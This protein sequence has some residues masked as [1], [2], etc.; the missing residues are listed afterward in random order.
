M[1]YPIGTRIR[2]RIVGKVSSGPL[3]IGK[4]AWTRVNSEGY[5]H[6]LFLLADSVVQTGDQVTAEF[7]AT[8]TGEQ[9]DSTATTMVTEEGSGANHFLYLNSPSVTVVEPEPERTY[10]EKLAARIDGPPTTEGTTAVT[11]EIGDRVRVRINA[12]AGAKTEPSLGLRA[13]TTVTENAGYSYTHFLYLNSNRVV[14]GS[15]SQVTAEFDA[16][17]TG[18]F[19]N[20][21]ARTTEVQEITAEGNPGYKHF[22]YLESSSIVKLTQYPDGSYRPVGL[23]ELAFSAPSPVYAAPDYSFGAPVPAFGSPVF[24]SGVINSPTVDEAIAARLR[25]DPRFENFT[26]QSAG[27]IDADGVKPFDY[28]AT[29]RARVNPSYRISTD[30]AVIQSAAVIMR[31]IKLEDALAK[32]PPGTVVRRTFARAG[33]EQELGR[34]ENAVA[35]EEFLNFNDYN[36]GRF[37]IDTL[38]PGLGEEDAEELQQ[39]R[40]LSEAGRNVFGDTTWAGGVLLLPDSFF[41][42]EWAKRQAEDE[43]K[44]LDGIDSWPLNLIDWSE[45]A[46]VRRETDYSCV[47]FGGG[48]WWGPNV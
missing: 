46:D 8:V 26:I 17:V 7:E 13:T 4:L 36:R 29:Q 28:L 48:D 14:S 32:L 31:I 38:A 10:Q 43:L 24:G 9:D 23:E 18:E 5:F 39:L 40:Q 25:A 33:Q 20:S 37:S 3:N 34:F 47:E 42:A 19:A 30:D 6:Y 35:A 16:K 44:P 21:K 15:G 11:F 1:A 27:V 45:A 22:L 12:T 41:T 2:V